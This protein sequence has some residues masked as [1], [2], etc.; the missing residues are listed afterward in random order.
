MSFFFVLKLVKLECFL[1]LVDVGLSY[2]RIT[3]PFRYSI[4]S[5]LKISKRLN[6]IEFNQIEQTKKYI[7]LPYKG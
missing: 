1:C 7:K 2:C 6:R 3:S 5:M 4:E